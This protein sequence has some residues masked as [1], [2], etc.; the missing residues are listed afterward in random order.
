LKL[1]F[2]YPKLS[3]KHIDYTCK[4][5]KETKRSY[6]EKFPKG[7]FFVY[8]HPYSK[9]KPE[10]EQCLK[11]SEVTLIKSS[12]T[13]SSEDVIPFDD[14]PNGSANRKIAAELVESLEL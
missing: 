6:L 2:N 5:I 13:W 8:A 11:S 10:I 7:S 4:L 3:Q 9:V 14:H 1:A 12:L